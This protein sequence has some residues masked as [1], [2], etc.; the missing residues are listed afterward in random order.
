M[1]LLEHEVAWRLGSFA[2]VLAVMAAAEALFPRRQRSVA[3][4]GRWTA[5][6]SLVVLDTMVVRYGLPLLPAAL[7]A[8]AAAGGWGGLN[9]L[10]LPGWLAVAAGVVWLDLIIYLQHVLFHKLPLLWRLHRVHHTDPDIDVTTGVRFHPVEILLSM[11]I[12][13]AAVAA[14]GVPVAA[15]ILFEI[16][17]NATSLF[18]HGNLRLPY[19]LDRLLRLLLVTPDMHRVHHSVIPRETDSNF[20]FNLSVWDRFLGTYRP[21]PEGGHDAMEIGLRQYRDFG[22]MTL[23][24]LLALPL[25]GERNQQAGKG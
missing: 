2:A 17:L 7:A 4:R 1:T 18:S 15:V 22:R 21:Q 13:L 25:A 24:W 6:L 5:N 14:M 8:E 16:L 23:G 11:V 20:G 12:K 10:P 3:R 9:R 19:G